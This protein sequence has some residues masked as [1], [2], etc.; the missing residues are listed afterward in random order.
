MSYE[1]QLIDQRNKLKEYHSLMNKNNAQDVL[2]E[3]FKFV[4]SITGMYYANGRM[5]KDYEK[6]LSDILCCQERFCLMYKIIKTDS[7]I[8][9]THNIDPVDF[10]LEYV[11]QEVIKRIVREDIYSFK[12]ETYDFTNFC[13]E[14]SIYVENICDLFN[15]PVYRIPIF[16][17][18]SRKADLFDGSYFHYASVIYYNQKYYL[19]D[20][21][22]SQFFW[23]S[24]NNINSI[25]IVN[26]PQR[27][28][29]TFM[30][31][32]EQGK[33]IAKKLLTS[34]Y[35]ELNEQVFK[36]YMDAFTMSFRNGL[37]YES[38]NDFS[39]T[40][41]YTTSDYIN[42]LRHKDNQINHE[43]KENLGFQRKPLINL[44]MDLSR[45]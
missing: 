24:K 23:A 40:T 8:N 45:R 36:T 4:K 18:Y 9:L 31:M 26:M 10:F 33:S 16:P 1:Q 32:T 30:L 17:G 41:P 11:V 39:Y 22:Y 44:Q 12:F 7:K 27:N 28:V 13:F 25:G 21:T 29:G 37:Y 35:I 2:T 42:F 19:I 3:A 20:P 14:S 38:T 5:K 34:G 6:I 15:V 43:G